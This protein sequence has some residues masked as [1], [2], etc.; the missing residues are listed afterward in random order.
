[1]FHDSWLASR[2]ARFVSAWL[3]VVLMCGFT[4]APVRTASG[5]T[6]RTGATERP[7]DIDLLVQDL[8]HLYF[9]D[10]D[11]LLVTW[12]PP[13]LFLAFMQAMGEWTPAMAE[14][15]Q[16]ALKPY[17]VFYVSHAEVSASGGYDFSPGAKLIQGTTLIDESGT[18]YQPMP[19]ER[20]DTSARA[21]ID[22]MRPGM[23]D[24]VGPFEENMHPVIFSA[25]DS[26]GNKIADAKLS[27]RFRLTVLNKTFNFR[28]PLGALVSPKKDPTTGEILNGAWTYSPWTGEKL[29]PVQ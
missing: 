6:Q 20:V 24:T 16:D 9:R 19:L 3:L 14:Q 11:Y 15:V 12:L 4:V 7:V 26:D 17:L 2:W 21:V 28:T 5:A 13:E 8:Q 1:M 18:A 23:E 29:V 22:G 27:G 10:N 25:R